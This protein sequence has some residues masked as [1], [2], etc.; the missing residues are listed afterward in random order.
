MFG[1]WCLVLGVGCWL[2]LSNFLI[3]WVFV[4]GCL[5][6]CIGCRVILSNFLMIWV[7]GVGCWV[8]SDLVQLSK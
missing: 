7:F 6:F 3:G 5:V 2:T 8:L 4:V 1:F